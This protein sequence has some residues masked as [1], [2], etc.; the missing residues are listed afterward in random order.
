VRK[1]FVLAVLGS[2]G[3]AAGCGGGGGQTPVGVPTGG[4]SGANVLSIALDGGPA[5]AT[6]GIYANGAFASATICAPGST[7]NCVKVDHLLVDTGSAGVRVLQSEVA[8][9]NLPTLNASNGSTAYDCVSFADG[10]LLWGTV[11]KANVTLAGET[12]SNIPI[13][14]ISSSNANIPSSCTN[15]NPTGDENTQALLGANGILG[16]GLE[17][18]DCF[19]EGGSACD[20]NGGLAQPPSPAYYTCASLPCSPQFVSVANQVTNPV[21]LF[22]TDNNG[23]IVELPSVSGSAATV[24]GSL[25]FGLGTESNNQLSSSVNVYTLACDDFNTI[26]QNQTFAIN[27][28]SCTGPG[29]FIDSGSNAF[30]FPNVTSPA[31][32]TCPSST[33]AG[34]LSSFYCPT[35][36]MNLSAVNEDP[37]TLFQG[38]QVKFSVDNTEN[39]FTS[40][41]TRSDAAFSTLG[42]VQPA[43]FGF[44][45]GLP[46]F[47]GRNVYVAI[48]GVTVPTNAAAPWW[49]Y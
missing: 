48:D 36:L 11:Q 4:G 6:N 44:D 27:P 32:P 45:W 22:S 21:A 40:A 16:V 31:I 30:F 2:L 26:F 3:L 37:N 25:I 24:T 18:T 17:P 7:S 39:L 35:S 42:G 46:F 8:S 5:P 34:D 33:P 1:L 28:S 41:S 9:L 23:V 12:A 15:G 13:H 10:S 19:F 49:A 29:S 47:Y 43:G 38:P 14:V 20:P